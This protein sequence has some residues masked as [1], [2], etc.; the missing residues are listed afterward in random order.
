M[1]RM[2]IAML[3]LSS[4][5]CLNDPV[6]ISTTVGK[7]TLESVNGQP[8]P[9]TMSGS[10][11]NKT[12]LISD[13]LMLYE[14]FTYDETIQLRTTVNGQ[15]TT[16]LTKEPGPYAISLGAL[17]FQSNKGLPS[18]IGKVEGNRMTIAETGFVQVFTK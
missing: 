2:V 14:G 6:G 10:G 15:A 16:T 8:L 17:V 3:A 18:K 11:S 9:Y 1:R 13:V 12:E 4:L 7:W 5:S